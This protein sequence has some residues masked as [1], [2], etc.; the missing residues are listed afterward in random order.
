MKNQPC[1]FASAKVE[2][3]LISDKGRAV[4]CISPIQKDEVVGI[5]GGE[6]LSL[7]EALSL[8]EDQKSQCLQI[9]EDHVLWISYFTQSTADW[10]N[11]SCSPNLGLSGQIT[12]I[13]LRDIAV[14]EEVCYDYAMSDGSNIDEFT[15]QCGAQAC[16]GSVTGRDW[17]NPVL[18]EVYAGHFSPY[19][20]RRIAK[21]KT[22]RIGK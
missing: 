4:F 3:R 7:Q 5:L 22:T 9:E 12:L 19:L 2:A 18:Q 10:I 21:L 16:R 14:D 15:C 13:A 6:L 1:S 8:S 11:H 20:D 17:M